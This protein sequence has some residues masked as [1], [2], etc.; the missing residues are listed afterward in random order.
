MEKKKADILQFSQTLNYVLFRATK[1]GSES[2]GFESWRQA[3]NSS[4]NSLKTLADTKQR[5]VPIQSQSM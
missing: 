4:R 3:Q 2:N 5:M 1:S